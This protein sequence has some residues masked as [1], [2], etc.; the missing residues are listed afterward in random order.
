M[1]CLSVAIA[2]LQ[3]FQSTSR[4]P[5]IIILRHLFV[6][7][8]SHFLSSRRL[9]IPVI[10]SAK[11]WCLW[12]FVHVAPFKINVLGGLFSRIKKKR[13]LDTASAVHGPPSQTNY[14]LTKQSATKAYAALILK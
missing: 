8:R 1:D 6:N 12:R 14:T 10:E 3:I 7:G 4:K 9:V 13:P 2:W 11:I 5:A